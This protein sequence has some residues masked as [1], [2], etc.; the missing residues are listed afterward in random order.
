MDLKREKLTEFDTEL[1]DLLGKMNRK[2]NTFIVGGYLRN[3]FYGIKETDVDFITMLSLE[4]IK[5]IFPRVTFTE[6]GL[7][8]GVCR[9]KYKKRQFDFSICKD[10]SEFQKKMFKRDF[11]VNSAFTDGIYVYYPGDTKRHLKEKCLV[12]CY[13]LEEHFE[14][15]DTTLI[16]VYRLISEFGFDVDEKTKA[17]LHSHKEKLHEIDS[18]IKRLEFQRIIKGS[19]AIKAIQLLWSIYFPK[20]G[21]IFSAISIEEEEMIGD[22]MK[23]RLVYLNNLLQQDYMEEV[24]ELFGLKQNFTIDF[25][26]YRYLFQHIEQIPREEF[27]FCLLVKRYETRDDSAQ[28]NIFL[29]QLKR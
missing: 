3:Q 2:G 19:H 11:T 18:F 23:A 26:R 13:S 20:R 1:T 29:N 17:F 10:E 24:I 5:E 27:A 7:E 15:S 8:F 21:D 9:A 28:L 25:E 14:Q 22:N 12:P 16:R 6:R 4:E